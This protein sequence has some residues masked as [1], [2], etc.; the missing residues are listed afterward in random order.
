MSFDLDRSERLHARVRA[1]I[2]RGGPADQRAFDALALELAAHQVDHV[3]AYGRLVQARGGLGRATGARDLPALPSDAFRFARIA[4]HPAELDVQVFRTSGTTRG[5]ELAG[6]HPLRTVETY[7]AAARA[8]A[9]RWLLRPR[10]RRGISLVPSAADAPSSSLAFMVGSFLG[11][12]PGASTFVAAADGAPDVDRFAGAAREARERAEPALVLATS[13]ALVLLL[14]HA[15][16]ADLELPEGSVV[17]VT[18]GFKGRSREV[19]APELYA[20]VAR[21]FGLPVEDVIGEYGMTELSSQLYEDP[22]SGPPGARV[23]RAPPWVSVAAADPD[24][25]AP[26]APGAE[27]VARFVDLANVD[28]VCALQTLDWIRVEPDGGV[29]LFGRAPGAPPRGCSLALEDLLDR[30]GPRP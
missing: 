8:W 6:A 4:A 9:Q 3:P 26:L 14:D 1:E 16:G 7:E 21:A 22:R 18:G 28:S 25:L 24:T 30:A 17:M 20:A 11:E 5:G 10:L 29:R 13:F 15:G 23:Y 19:A 12:L 27:G 2:A